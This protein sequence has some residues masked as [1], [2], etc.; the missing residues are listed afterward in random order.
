[1]KRRKGIVGIEAAIVLI[2]FVIVAAA[3]AFVVLNMGMTSTQKTKE[4]ISASMGEAGSSLMVDGEVVAYYV[5]NPV[6]NTGNGTVTY[7]I[8]GVKDV[9]IPLRIA[10]GKYPVDLN[11]SKTIISVETKDSFYAN[12]YHTAPQTASTTD[13]KTLIN[14]F[15]N[16]AIYNNTNATVYFITGDGD[17]MLEYGEKAV[18][19]VH[20]GSPLQAYDTVKIEIKPPEG[21]PLLVERSI[22]ASL[23]ST[24]GAVSLG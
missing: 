16:T 18:L 11:K 8:T 17:T 12:V 24:S 13:I 2:A 1:M 22:P 5:K 9:V 6:V 20:F 14:I 21:S 19:V 3:L 15:N 10:S 4:A 23:P 7:N